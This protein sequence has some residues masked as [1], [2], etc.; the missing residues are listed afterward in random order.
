[1]VWRL[2]SG[3]KRDSL[4]GSSYDSLSLGAWDAAGHHT[5]VTLRHN[6]ARRSRNEPTCG[7]LACRFLP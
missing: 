5:P 7:V 3:G 4:L 6:E 1:M 2:G